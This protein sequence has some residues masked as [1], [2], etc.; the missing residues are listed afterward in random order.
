MVDG[1]Y[2]DFKTPGTD[3]HSEA[4]EVVFR[5]KYNDNCLGKAD[6]TVTL[7]IDSSKPNCKKQIDE[8]IYTSKFATA[9]T[10][11]AIKKL[12]PGVK[13]SPKLD[14][15]WFVAVAQCESDTVS[16]N[17]NAQGKSVTIQKADFG[18]VVVLIDFLCVTIFIYFSSC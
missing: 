10:K 13:A 4:G 2:T 6:C 11:E 1:C 14:E 7:D 12:Y 3:F 8:R 16:I 9:K 15:P 17:V 18:I 5:K